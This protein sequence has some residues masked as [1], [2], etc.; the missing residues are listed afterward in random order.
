MFLFSDGSWDPFI[1]YLELPGSVKRKRYKNG[2]E[3]Q[4]YKVS[5]LRQCISTRFQLVSPTHPMC[6]PIQSSCEQLL[7]HACTHRIGLSMELGTLSEESPLCGSQTRSQCPAP[8]PGPP[9]GLL[10]LPLPAAHLRRSGCIGHQSSTCTPTQ[11]PP[12]HCG[13]GAC[14]KAHPSSPNPW[15]SAQRGCCMITVPKR[16]IQCSALLSPAPCVA[17]VCPRQ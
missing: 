6:W 2:L 5:C 9:T 15:H 11:S 13:T 7:L 12:A 14:D 4:D 16:P 10:L 8:S 3:T 17:D 1:D